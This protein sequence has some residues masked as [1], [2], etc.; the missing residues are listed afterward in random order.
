MTLRLVGVSLFSDVAGASACIGI[1]IN[2][3]LTGDSFVSAS[4][5]S[6]AEV[7]TAATAVSGGTLIASGFVTDQGVVN[8]LT[9]AGGNRSPCFDI[10]ADIAGTSDILSLVATMITGSPDVRASISW[11]EIN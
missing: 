8:I 5:D 7:D 6:A 2:P 3:T 10:N 4:A 11:I 9:S 1:F